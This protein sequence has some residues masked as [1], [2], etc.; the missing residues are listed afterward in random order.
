MAYDRQQIF[1][2]AKEAIKEHS[3]YFIED[4][5]AYLPIAKKTYYEY[6]PIESNESNELKGLLE[7]NKIKMKV[8]LRQKLSKGEKAAEIL[9]LYKLIC[10][11]EERKALQMVYSE[12]KHEIIT[13]PIQWVNEPN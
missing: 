5:V 1:E 6:F 7:E 9:A 11:D 3:L 4:I 2:Q 10:S 8:Q 13:P 12:N